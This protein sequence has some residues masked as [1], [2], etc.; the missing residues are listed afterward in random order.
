MLITQTGIFLVETS[1]K[2]QKNNLSAIKI[3]NFLDL[4]SVS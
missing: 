3:N 1:T 2:S 4:K